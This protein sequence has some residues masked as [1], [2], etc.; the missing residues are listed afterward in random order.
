MKR[1]VNFSG[2]L[3]SFWA[4]K[5]VIDRFGTDDVTLLFADTLV[6]SPELYAFN[7]TAAVYLGVPI[8]R[9]SIEMNPWDLFRKEGMIGNSLTPICSIRLKREPLDKWRELN[10]DKADTILYIGFDWTEEH[11]L[12]KLREQKPDWKIEAPMLDEPIWDKCLMEKEARAIGLPISSAYVQGFPHNN[13][14]RRCVK[15][16]ISQWVRLL[17]TDPTAF[18]EWEKEE[19]AT[20]TEFKRRGINT[21][22]ATML[23]DRRGGVKKA[24]TLTTVRKRVEAGEKMPKYD[25][26]GC[27]CGSD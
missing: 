18:N 25:W 14:N 7:D 12:V 22:W 27:G 6:E 23:K 16:G 19:Q 11:R 9:L 10:C 5:R 20:I 26:G 8:I 17:V 3:C 21:E 15:A 2:G 24:M 4:A 13:C 1:V